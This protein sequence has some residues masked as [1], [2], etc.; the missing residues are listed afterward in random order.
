MKV[1]DG[2][3]NDKYLY[4]KSFNPLNYE[5]IKK[6]VEMLNYFNNTSFVLFILFISFASYADNSGKPLAEKLQDGKIT[7]N[8]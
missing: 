6:G 2:L 8:S 4:I 7:I 1:E 5:N 3:C